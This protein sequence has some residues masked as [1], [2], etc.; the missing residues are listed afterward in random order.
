[1]V[2]FVVYTISSSFIG[3]LEFVITLFKWNCFTHLLLSLRFIIVQTIKEWS[4]SCHLVWFWTIE[5][6]TSCHFIII[7]TDI[8]ACYSSWAHIN[9]SA[10]WIIISSCSSLFSFFVSQQLF[11]LRTELISSSNYILHIKYFIFQIS[12]L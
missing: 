4:L 11:S 10:S 2:V 1:M 5:A 3:W 9:T 6:T 7:L 12:N 8:L